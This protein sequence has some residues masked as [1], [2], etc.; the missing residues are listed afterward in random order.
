MEEIFFVCVEVEEV[1]FSIL[2]LG[3]VWLHLSTVKTGKRDRHQKIIE[4]K[5]I[6]SSPLKILKVILF[7]ETLLTAMTTET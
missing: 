4:D 2:F 1:E 3:W 5:D 7:Y 6:E